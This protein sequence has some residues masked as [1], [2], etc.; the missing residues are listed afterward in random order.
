MDVINDIFKTLSLE[1]SLYFRTDFTP[2]WGVTVPQYEQ[3]V[4]FHLVIQ[5]NC[6]INIKG[7]ESKALSTGDFIMVFGGASHVLSH[8]PN[9]KSPPLETVLNDAG[10]K[11]NGVLCIGQGDPRATTQLVCGHLNFR[12]Y[13]SHPLLS[14]MPDHLLLS[15]SCRAK[16]PLLDDIL[17][18]ISQRIFL[19]QIGIEASIIR[20]AEIIFLEML[21]IG[22]DEH[23]QLQSIMDAVK[24]PQVGRSLSLIHDQ[25]DKPWTV[26]SLASSVAM[27][28]S[29]FSNRFSEM[30]GIS[31]IKYLSDWRLQKAMSLLNHS[32]LS[33]QQIAIQ[34]GHHSA[35]AFTRAFSNKFGFPPSHCR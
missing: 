26:D 25:L 31:P 35:S 6:H 12:Q 29:R 14:A 5:G 32:Q 21:S 33:V 30:L 19:N 3:S 4:R 10:Y 20:L 22:F 27:S 16:H 2:P 17:R 8:T 11:G 34:T 24:D 28:R 23:P 9:A 1:G 18:L 15:N 13:A 7:G